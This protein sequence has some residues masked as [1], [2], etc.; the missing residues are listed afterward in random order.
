M[1]YHAFH[2]WLSFAF[3]ACILSATP[4]LLR[5]K[6]SVHQDAAANPY[7]G[8]LCLA[9][10]LLY[11]FPP[12]L[13]IPRSGWLSWAFGHIYESNYRL[14]C[15]CHF[16][17]CGEL[18]LHIHAESRTLH[19]NHQDRWRESDHN[20]LRD[21]AILYLPIYLQISSSLLRSSHKNT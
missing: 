16:M 6:I 8:R 12:A 20:F 5:R 2:A 3:P 19:N 10:T 18:A 15:I 4:Q 17:R 7:R 13:L 9:N 11:R 1:R 21:L 14:F